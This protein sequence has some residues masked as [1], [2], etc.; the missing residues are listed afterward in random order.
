MTS[1]EVSIAAKGTDAW[2]MMSNQ[3]AKFRLDKFSRSRDIRVIAMT[4]PTFLASPLSMDTPKLV[5]M[6]S[7]YMIFY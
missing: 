2:E 7:P 3:R 6:E 4:P 1:L 5:P